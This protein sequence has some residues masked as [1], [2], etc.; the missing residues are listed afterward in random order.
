MWDGL[1]QTS[2]PESSSMEGMKWIKWQGRQLDMPA[3]WQE[4]KEVPD[5]DDLQQFTRRVQA[6][7]Q[8][9]KVRCHASRVDNIHSTLLVPHSLDGD[10]FLPLP[11]MWYS[12][13]D[14]CLTQPYRTLT[15]TKALHYWAEK[16]QLPVPSEPHQFVENVLE[17]QQLMELLTTFT[18]EE[19]L[20]DVLPSNWVKNTLSRLPEPTQQEHTCSRT[21]QAHAKESFLVAYGKGWPQPHATATPRLQADLLHQPWRWCHNGQ[22]LLVNPQ[23]LHWGLQRLLDP[24]MGIGC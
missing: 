18:D 14:F 23:H 10:Q 15:Y 1:P 13:Q 8:V 22:N 16:A 4:L 20:E 17:L 19:V 6:S 7:F 2:M 12:S 24:C 5:Q 9:P 11:D 3:W 21:C